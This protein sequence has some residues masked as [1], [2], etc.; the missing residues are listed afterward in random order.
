MLALFLRGKNRCKEE[1]DKNKLILVEKQKG[2]EVQK[3]KR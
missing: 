1:M 3:T 2:K